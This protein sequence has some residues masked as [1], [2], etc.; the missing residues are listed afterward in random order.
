MYT[1]NELI[2]KVKKS[3][4]Q[5]N[6]NDLAYWFDHNYS[7]AWNGEEYE[8]KELN[9]RLRPKYKQIRRRFLLSATF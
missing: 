6:L 9:A 8:V 4:S 7:S 3:P 1:Y 2:E 5:S